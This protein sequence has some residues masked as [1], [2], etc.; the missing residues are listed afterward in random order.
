MG[1]HN[2]LNKKIQ[3]KNQQNIHITNTDSETDQWYCIEIWED[4]M[5][6]FKADFFIVELAEAWPMK[7]EF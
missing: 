5:Q 2:Y 4:I 6:L 1:I 7:S 3:S